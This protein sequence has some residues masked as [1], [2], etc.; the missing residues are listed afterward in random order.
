[1]SLVCGAL[2]KPMVGLRED[3]QT[4]GTW[5]RSLCD[6]SRRFKANVKILHEGS[7]QQGFARVRVG[8]SPDAKARP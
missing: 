1:M 8:L 2:I 6:Y 5:R 7:G 3:V 4:A